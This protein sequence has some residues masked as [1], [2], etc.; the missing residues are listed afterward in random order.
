M[1]SSPDAG[2]RRATHKLV[3]TCIDKNPGIIQD[4]INPMSNAYV[5]KGLHSIQT[6]SALDFVKTLEAAT[7]TFPGIWTDSYNG[8]K[9]AI[10]R[11]RHFLKQGSQSSSAE[12]WDSLNSLF[13]K[14]PSEIWPI[15]VEDISE[16]IASA[17][18]GVSR[19]EERSNAVSA[20]FTYFNLVGIVTSSVQDAKC[21]KVLQTEVLPVL[22]QYLY[23]NQ[24]NT[25]W[26]I[27]SAKAA[28]VISR[29]ANI[30][31][32]TPLLIQQWPELA[33]K[34]IELAKMSQPE[35]S[36]DYGKSQTNVAAAGERW[37]SLQ[38]HFWVMNHSSAAELREV[39]ETCNT[40]ILNDCIALLK[41]RNGKPFGAA[42]IVEHLLRSC[43]DYLLPLEDF[44][45]SY[46]FFVENDMPTLTFGPSG[47]YLAKGLLE[48]QLQSGLGAAFGNLLRNIADSSLHEETKIKALGTLFAQDAPVIAA[49]TARDTPAFQQ[50]VVKRASVASKNGIT[51]LFT[52]LVRLDAVTPET[53]NAVLASLTASLN[54]ASESAAGLTAIDNIS[55]SNQPAVQKF[56]ASPNGTGDQLLPNLLRLEQSPDDQ[57][58]EQAA[59]LSSR[60]S[61]TI[62]ETASSSRFAVVLRNLERVSRMSLQMDALHDLTLRLLGTERK[63]PDPQELLPSSEVWLSALLAILEPPA[64]S[65]ALMST[66]G[67]AVHLVQ[68]PDDEFRPHVQYDTEGFSQAL[69]IAMFVSKLLTETE[70]IE[71]LGK[72]KATT[73]ACL[74]LSVLVAEDSVSVVGSNGLW[75]EQ[76][77]MESEAAI[78]DFISEANAILA[79]YSEELLP[80]P[81][82]DPRSEDSRFFSALENLR[83]NQQVTSPISYYVAACVARLYSNL[84]ELHGFSTSQAQAC[85]A[86]I[87]KQRSENRQLNLVSYIVGFQQPLW[88]TPTLARVSN[89]VVAYLTDADVEKDELN[90]FTQL[91]LLTTILRTQEDVLTGIPKQRL[92]FLAKHLLGS[93]GSPI[94]TATKS[95]VLRGLTYLLAGIDDMYGEHWE[96]ALES[97]ITAWALIVSESEYGTID[98]GHLLLENTSLRLLAALR[99]LARSEEPNDDLVDA[100]KEKK[101]KIQE[102]LV[103]LLT[104][105]NGISDEDHQ[106]LRITHELL[107]RQI[108]ATPIE[109][110][111]NFDDIYPIV[112]APSRSIQQAAFRLLH[113]EI[114]TAQEQ[115]SFDAAIDNKTAQLPDE[116]LSLVLEAPTLDSLADASFQ[117]T[118]P[119]PLQGYLYSWRLIFDHFQGSSYKVKSDYIEQLKD[120]TYL[121]GLLN[122][123]FDFL[124]HTN[125][126]PVDATKFNLQDYTSDAEPTPEK[127][128]QSL[129][130]HLYY[131]A[132]THLPS[133]VR[134]YYLEI[135]SRQLPQTIESWTAKHVSPFII[136]ASLKDVLAWAEKPKEDPEFEKVQ[137]KVG[138]RSREITVSYEVDEQIMSMKIVLPEAYPLASPQVVGINRVAV[139]EEKWQSWLRN[140]QGVIA[141][142]VRTNI[143]ST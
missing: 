57:I 52:E 115:I 9:T 22:Q 2:V 112:Y 105:A 129:L 114:P 140:C 15:S 19:R 93:L 50:F 128:V 120:G 61:S 21:E 131:L 1:V 42:A 83:A 8:K 36:K 53:T 26:N 68:V 117:D 116:L 79:T 97:V 7:S 143:P 27:A 67:G 38:K 110:L 86:I 78:L 75:R 130:S 109:K 55:R 139:N 54:V 51:S 48:T 35:Q 87:K 103:K 64:P 141:F 56:I 100:L 121:A 10:S 34:L 70:M 132:L 124:G 63:V 84:F 3:R 102:V 23:P 81:E 104:V 11:L 74:Q 39:L 88:G 122:L 43:S 29:V 13:P 77:A 71:E 137:F 65:L 76:T 17:R 95:E 94:D 73:L 101:G 16:I 85:E 142:S 5:Y 90:F 49:L 119:V 96:Q 89:E 60:L 41:I 28:Y 91:N 24:E 138:F 40:K 123:T 58:A 107:A 72:S 62:S 20:W 6:G 12:F 47:R 4:N 133:L 69:R 113:K 31:R 25:E 106:P 99:K 108:A 44:R 92:I 98:E 30:D 37:A 118:M 80:R 46:T 32:V 14:I 111:A 134:S 66:L 45:V 33:D 59:A 135:R 126:R 127:D 136:E 82:T 18:S 125:G